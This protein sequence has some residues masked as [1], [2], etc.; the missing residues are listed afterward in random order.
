MTLDE[1]VVEGVVVWHHNDGVSACGL[2][3]AQFSEWKLAG[4]QRNSGPR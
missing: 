2:F 1:L 3:S 4:A